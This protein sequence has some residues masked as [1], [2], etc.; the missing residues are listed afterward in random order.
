MVAT[1]RIEYQPGKPIKVFLASPGDVP[2][3]RAFVRD[4]LREVLPNTVKRVGER[5][6]QF[7]VVSWDDKNDPLTMPAHLTPQEA[8]IRPR[9]VSRSEKCRKSAPCS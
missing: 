4:H 2:E 7:E 1:K 3:E 8:V 5:D 6:I 9:G